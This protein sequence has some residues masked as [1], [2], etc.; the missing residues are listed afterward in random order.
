MRIATYFASVRRK[1]AD[2][3]AHVLS[4]L[5]EGLNALGVAEA[6]AVCVLAFSLDRDTKSFY[7]SFTMTGTRSRNTNRTYTW[8]YVVHDL[9]DRYLTDTELQEAYDR[10]T[11]IAQRPNENK[12]HYAD[13]IVAAARDCSNVFEDHALVQY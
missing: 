4:Q 8:P 2:F 12:N 11:L 3:V 7:D 1:E 5:R 6:A 13:R 10:V 9:I